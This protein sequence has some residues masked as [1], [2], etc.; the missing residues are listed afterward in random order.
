VRREEKEQPRDE[1]K[2][3]IP[4]PGGARGGFL[5]LNI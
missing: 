5:M 3:R 4:L 2:L 1:S